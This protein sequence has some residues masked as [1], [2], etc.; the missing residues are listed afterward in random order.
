LKEK[1]LPSG[2][3]MVRIDG[4]LVRQ[5]REE[6]GL[7]QLYLATAVGVTTDTV[8]RWEN[9]HYQSVKLE[10]AQRVAEA[11][12]VELAAIL[13]V[14]ERGEPSEKAEPG[15][16]P[17]VRGNRKKFLALWPAFLALLFMIA[18][19]IVY[20]R[21]KEPVPEIILTATRKTP[22]H[23]LPGSSFPVVITVETRSTPLSVVIRETLP[24][25][26]RVTSSFA[27]PQ[28]SAKSELKWVIRHMSGQQHFG[29]MA[30]APGHEDIYFHGSVTTREGRQK[31]VVIGGS[32]SLTMAPFHWADSN[33]DGMISDEEILV[34]YD[35]FAE[36]PGL[37]VD[38][39]LVEEMWMGS[40]YRWLPEK[41][42]FEI[43]PWE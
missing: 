20:S 19:L 26:V 23:A 27:P 6:K 31:E 36:V 11:L 33:R 35:D 13:E 14:K 42:V 8:S 22:T 12:D 16:P 3:V 21:F 32:Q 4:R 9:R 39:E 15:Q 40:G 5:L 43:I 28:P 29:Y 17:P 30:T 37:S 10:N 38:V 34:V 24:P 18:A 41:G 2:L 25:G 1:N 7:T